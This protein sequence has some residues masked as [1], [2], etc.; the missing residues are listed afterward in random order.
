MIDKIT[1]S[2]QESLHIAADTASDMTR[3]TQERVSI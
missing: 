1:K 3:T 2:L